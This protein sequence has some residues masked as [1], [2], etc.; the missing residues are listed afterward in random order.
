MPLATG[1]LAPWFTIDSTVNSRFFFPSI[2]DK[3]VVLF[4]F[5]SLATPAVRLAWQKLNEARPAL[6]DLNF[7]IIGVSVDPSDREDQ[8]LRANA[9]SFIT[10]WDMDMRLSAQFGVASRTVGD[11]GEWAYAPACC[12]LDE[13]LRVIQWVPLGEPASCAE[14]V[15]AHIRALPPKPAPRHVTQTAPVLFVPDVLSA[16]MCRRLIRTWEE[17]GNEDSGYMERDAEGRMVG[18]IDYTRKRRRDHFVPPG[19][20]LY[21]ELSRAVADRVLPLVKRAYH[22]PITRVERFCIACYDSEDGGGYFKPHRDFS[23]S[24][25]HRA[26]AMTLNL[27]EG[28]Y[29]GGYLKFPEF[30]PHLYRPRTGEAVLFSGYL[31]HEAMPVTKGRRFVL[32]SFFYGEKE[33]EVRRA[34]ESRHGSKHET[35]RG[36]P[37]YL[38]EAAE[39]N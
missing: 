10:F 2:G 22:Y 28:D 6:L 30:G 23:G 34:Y 19:S 15:L 14:R 20:P 17:E 37:A 32:L 38:S 29:E 9:S 36:Q 7:R 31:M 25:S 18:Y 3:P 4:F 11:Q 27:N 33:A 26:F 8:M 1:D 13:T 35:V 39:V 21:A 16:D 24:G 12:L 5:G